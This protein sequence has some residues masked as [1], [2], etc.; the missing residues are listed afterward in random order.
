MRLHLALS[1]SIVSSLLL[2]ACTLPVNHE[3]IRAP[4]TV[5]DDPRHPELALLEVRLAEH[6]AKFAG[7]P[8]TTCAGFAPGTPVDRRRV[9]GLADG[10]ERRLMRRFPA[11]APFDRCSPVMHTDGTQFYV[12]S[13]TGE[14]AAMIDVHGLDC[15]GPAEC[16]GYAGY[17]LDETRNG[18]RYYVAR[19]SDGKWRV[20]EEELDIIV[21]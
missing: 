14:P 16:R 15:T 4:N 6:F 7:T 19:F 13:I 10:E 12:D 2:G 17:R 3:L 20:R 9:G 1:A 21:T 18:W 11:L 8:P 5:A